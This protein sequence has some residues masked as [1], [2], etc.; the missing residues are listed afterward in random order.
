MFSGNEWVIL[1]ALVAVPAVVVVVVLAIVAVARGGQT[2]STATPVAPVG[3]AVR[4]AARVVSRSDGRAR[5]ALLG[6][7]VLDGRC[8]FRRE[9]VERSVLTAGSYEGPPIER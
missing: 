1:M 8:R 7:I 2:R 6:R 5:P 3:C 4:T 9:A